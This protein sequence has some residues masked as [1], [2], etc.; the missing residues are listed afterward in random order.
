M[1][2][3]IP[4]PDDFDETLIRR[5]VHLFYGKIR[6]DDLL[7]PV[8]HARIPQENWGEHLEKMC[9]FWSSSFLRTDRYGG[10]PL[11]PHLAIGELSDAHFERWLNL[12]RET[13]DATCSPDSARGFYDLARRIAHSFRLAVAFHRGEDTVS[14]LPF[15]EQ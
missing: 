8:F 10:R 14:I 3:G 4:L 1:P 11:P 12:F 5:V 9:D 15:P 2:N 6:N 13:V 7:G